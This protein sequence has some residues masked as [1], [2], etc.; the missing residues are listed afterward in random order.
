MELNADMMAPPR[1]GSVSLRPS[2]H[3]MFAMKCLPF[4]SW[5]SY[6]NYVR[7]SLETQ[8]VSAR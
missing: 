8:Y 2:L 1:H 6:K 4:Q 3:L 7:M 5:N